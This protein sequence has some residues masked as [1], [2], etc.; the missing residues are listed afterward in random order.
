MA[1]LNDAR[2][3]GLLTVLGGMN[4][5]HKGE[6]MFNTMPDRIW[7]SAQTEFKQTM[8]I[9]GNLFIDMGKSGISMTK[10]DGMLVSGCNFQLQQGELSIS[11]GNPPQ[12]RKL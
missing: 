10:A 5:S 6:K 2:V 1:S 12:V 4:L 7:V 11:T 8:K 9:V 3:K